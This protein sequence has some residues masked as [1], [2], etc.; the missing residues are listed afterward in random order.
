MKKA[1]VLLAAVAIVLVTTSAAFA[2][3]QPNHPRPPACDISQGAAP[4][5]NPH[6]TTGYP[7]GQSQQAQ[8]AGK[9]A[10]FEFPSEAQSSGITV[11]VLIMAV[12]G[13]VTLFLVSRAVARRRLIS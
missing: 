6:C 3:H 10:S 5:K 2:T 12:L 11:G 7:P 1:A 13:A 4:D 9:K 8:Q